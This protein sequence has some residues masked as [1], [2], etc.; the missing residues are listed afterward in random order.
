[1]FD[2][3]KVKAVLFD[4]D[5]TLYSRVD[6]A[7]GVFHGMFKTHLYKSADDSF[8]EEA[9]SYMMKHIKPNS[10]VHEDTF[11]ALLKKYPSEIPYNRKNCLDYYYE[12][13][14]EFA[15]PDKEAFEIIK[16]L[17]SMGIKTAVVTN[18]TPD[19][20][21]SQKAKIKALGLEKIMDLIV[22]SGEIGIHK[23]DK[24]IYEYAA[25]ALGVLP[26]ECVF[27]GDDPNSDIKGAVG[28]DMEAVWID[29]WNSDDDIKRSPKVTTVT[30]IDEYFKF[31]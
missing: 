3:E 22:M 10:M 18:I 21:D 15:K 31:L 19:R 27:V 29:R 14:S 7:R 9:V 17:R 23:P 26:S 1:M 24:R 12:H 6:A 30:K 11:E 25:D 20:L 8:I 28:A 2:K 13:I 16:R 5:D 4:L